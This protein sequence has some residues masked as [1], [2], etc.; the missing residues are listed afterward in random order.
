M[1]GSTDAGQVAEGGS[2][3][4]LASYRRCIDRIRSAWPAFVERR[5][6]FLQQGLFDAPVER[7]AENVL[8]EL[9]TVVLDWPIA[10][11]NFQIGRA[12]IVLSS[13]GIK[14]LI[15]EVKRPG[16]LMWQRR[17]V[18]Q[19]LEQARRYA[20]EQHVEAVAVSDGEMLYAADVAGGGLH[21][22]VLVE[23]DVRTPPEDL[24]WISVHGIY[25]SSPPI[26]RTRALL[27]EDPH[28]ATETSPAPGLRHPRYQLPVGCFAY[29]GAV[30]DTSTWKLPYLLA[31]GAP[32]TKRL[33]KA[34]QSVL[35]NYRGARVSIPRD[36]IGDVLVRLGATAA[37]LS[38]MPCQC[39][40]AAGAYVDAHQALLQL[41]RLED[42]G[43]CAGA[44]SLRGRD[45]NSQPNG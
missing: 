27:P 45:S 43:C 21:D 23:L 38:K 30:D 9:F 37:A 3:L 8:Q 14:H 18:T 19:A 41:D 7:V 4:K 34:I 13:L 32:D 12:D 10:D 33:P 28:P 11:V 2:H 42:V 25:R 40:N 15:V 22:R 26:V 17:A 24:W 5:R 35:S 31:D 36:A 44:P 6:E 20:S 29:V 1:S 39:E 16:S